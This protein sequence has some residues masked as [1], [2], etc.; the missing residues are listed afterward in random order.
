[1][2]GTA[3]RK[4][5]RSRLHSADPPSE[6]GPEGGQKVSVGAADSAETP[7]ASTPRNRA[8]GETPRGQFQGGEPWDLTDGEIP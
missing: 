1:M 6:K 7:R 3:V 8:R 5:I 2:R 4:E